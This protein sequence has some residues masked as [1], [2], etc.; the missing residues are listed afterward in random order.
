MSKSKF[1]GYLGRRMQEHLELRRA[2]GRDYRAN[3]GTLARFNQLVQRSWPN[4]KSVTREMVMAFLRTN[5]SAKTISRKNELTYIR[6]F[7]MDLAAQGVPVYLP[8]R[9]LLP[10]S[11]DSVRVHI[12]SESE[13]LK[14]MVAAGSLCKPEVRLVY[15]TLVGFFW[16]TG[17]RLQEAL[18]AN[19]GDID[20]K[21]RLFFVRNGKY[22]KSR[23]VPV[24]QSTLSALDSHLKKMRAL[25]IPTGDKNPL[26]VGRSHRRLSKSTATHNLHQLYRAAGIKTSWGGYP[27]T[28][29]L[30]H[31]FATHSLKGVQ[32]NGIDPGNKIPALAVAMGH[33]SLG[34][35]QT[36]LHPTMEILQVASKAFEKKLLSFKVA[37]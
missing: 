7:C 17:L 18:S 26:F 21:Q 4:K 25:G 6:M 29:D 36:Y 16:T 10:K 9:E 31:S 37:A 27:R 34:S 19:I 23:W 1:T 33:A 13:I 20:W 15:A 14:I 5:R 30:R 12:F 2:I 3:E 8:E 28:V 35:T 22:G 11:S 24:S 32:K